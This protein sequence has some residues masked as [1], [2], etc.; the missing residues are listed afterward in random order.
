[1]TTSFAHTVRG[2]LP[3]ALA[4]QPFG[5]FLCV[6]TILCVPIF[7]A[8][9]ITGRSVSLPVGRLPWNKLGPLLLVALFAAWGYKIAAMRG[10]F[11]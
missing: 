3:S 8:A 9:A 5:T 2:E 7:T 4:A 11:G 6:M 1:M 10:L